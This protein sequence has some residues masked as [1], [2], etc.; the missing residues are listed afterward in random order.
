MRA[1]QTRQEERRA[2]EGPAT[3]ASGSVPRRPAGPAMAAGPQDL[4]DTA[5]AGREPVRVVLVGAGIRGEIYGH[6]IA[7]HPERADVVAVAEPHPDRRRIAASRHGLPASALFEDWREL[8]GRPRFADAVIITTQDAQHVE[9]AV[10][11]AEA[12]YAVLLEKPIAPT[13]EECRRVVDAVARNK[14]PFGVCHVLRYTPYTRVLRNLLA[15]GRIGEIVNVDHIEPVGFAHYAHSYVRGNWRREQTS[16]P[17]LLAKSCH[18][19]DWLGHIV[20][21]P[22]R[23]VSSFGS[24][25][26]F[27]PGNRPV[28]AADRCPDCVL[29]DSCAYS[30]VRIYGEHLAAGDLAWPLS[31]LTPDPTEQS[32]AAALRTG[33]YGRCVWA[34]DNDVVDRQVV[35]LEFDGGVTATFTMTAFST[36]RPRMTHIFGT[37]GEIFCDGSIIRVTDFRTRETQTIDVTAPAADDPLLSGHSGGDAGLMNDFITAVA[38]WDDHWITG[39]AA[40][41]LAA[42]ELVFAAERAR[43]ERRVVHLG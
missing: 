13:E 5:A 3:P 14:V 33:P 32:V 15:E 1:G 34:C 40:E 2:A 36:S 39:T 24:L 11:F 28:V 8:V 35:A 22:V 31:V 27:V 38:T 7:E 41:A 12:G 37:M 42:H 18:D 17:M 26:Y 29:Q 6:W 23:A 43:R 10:A 21:R 16:A 9:P 25:S 20:G 4:P 19:L 30:A